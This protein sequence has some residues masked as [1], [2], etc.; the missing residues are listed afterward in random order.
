MEGV[1][2]KVEKSSVSKKGRTR[3]CQEAFESLGL[4]P[5]DDIVVSSEE[6]SITL[7]AFTDDMVEEDTIYLRKG[8]LNNLEVKVGDKVMVSPHQP[9]T[10]KVKKKIPWSKKDKT[11]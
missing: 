1:K 6:K 3:L 4:K 2:L 5:G 9:L 11:G 7:A 10:D 8:D